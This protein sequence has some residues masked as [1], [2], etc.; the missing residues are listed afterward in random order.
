MSK[1]GGGRG[2]NQHK[3]KGTSQAK[4]GGSTAGESA[5]VLDAEPPVN[6]WGLDG[7][8]RQLSAVVDTGFD[9]QTREDVKIYCDSNGVLPWSQPRPTMVFI[10]EV[11]GRAHR[12]LSDEGVSAQE[13]ADALNDERLEAGVFTADN[14]QVDIDKIDVERVLTVGRNS[15]FLVYHQGNERYYNRWEPR[16]PATGQEITAVDAMRQFGKVGYFVE[17][18]R[19]QN[20]DSDTPVPMESYGTISNVWDNEIE[21]ADQDG[22]TYTIPL[23]SE[24]TTITKDPDGR[25]TFDIP[26]VVTDAG[27]VSP[28]ARYRLRIDGEDD[29]TGTRPLTDDKGRESPFDLGP[30]HYGANPNYSSAAAEENTALVQDVHDPKRGRIGSIYR[31]EYDHGDYHWAI[32]PDS[33]LRDSADDAPDFETNAEAAEWLYRSASG[34]GSWSRPTAE[35]IP[36]PGLEQAA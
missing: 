18:D 16:E 24:L 12:A 6:L 13:I 31:Y 36:L 22:G 35:N 10:T 4:R 19:F 30:R 23:S 34:S 14:E 15:G 27:G 5:V 25:V 21:V 29:W 2:T 9:V 11:L 7:A 17:F 3:I 8:P 33:E 26:Q 1:T 28:G 20:Q 32:H